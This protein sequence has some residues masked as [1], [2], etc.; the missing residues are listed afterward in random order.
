MERGERDLWAVRTG[1]RGGRA[2][3][4]LHGASRKERDKT[5]G[6]G[7]AA[8]TAVEVETQGGPDGRT[9][10]YLVFRDE[11]LHLLDLLGD[12]LLV[13]VSQGGLGPLQPSQQRL[14]QLLLSDEPGQGAGQ[15]LLVLLRPGQHLSGEQKLPGF[16]PS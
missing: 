11:G 15:P 12:D 6:L 2:E 4:Q 1:C 13:L 14:Q 5:K 16:L 10:V 7:R 8:W 9:A 3:A